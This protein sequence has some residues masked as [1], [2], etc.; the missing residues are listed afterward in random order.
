MTRMTAPII[1]TSSR[2]PLWAMTRAVMSRDWLLPL[3]VAL[4]EEPR[5]SWRVLTKKTEY[6]SPLANDF[7]RSLLS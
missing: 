6:S 4:S 2:P 7:S 1:P 3:A 5:T